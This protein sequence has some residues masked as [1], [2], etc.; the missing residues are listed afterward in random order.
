MKA[1][2]VLHVHVVY[3]LRRQL[4]LRIGEAQ[5]CRDLTELPEGAQGPVYV[6]QVGNVLQIGYWVP[7]TT[8]FDH[9][10]SPGQTGELLE[11]LRRR[12]EH[13]WLETVTRFLDSEWTVTEAREIEQCIRG[14]A[15]DPS[16]YRK[17]VTAADAFGLVET[18]GKMK[19]TA[20]RPAQLYRVR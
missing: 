9:Q 12:V 15:M 1:A 7:A 20:T 13:R 17:R 16:N 4:K 5:V 3:P 2:A 19:P 6:H 14:H 11:D 18:T 10:A 8:R